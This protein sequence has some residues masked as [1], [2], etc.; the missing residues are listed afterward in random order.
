MAAP[1][2]RP[3]PITV[4]C[5]VGFLS[6]LIRMILIASPYSLRA[7]RAWVPPLLSLSALLLV[8]GSYFLF[9]MGRLGVWL[10]MGVLALQGIIVSLIPGGVGGLPVFAVPAL[11]L[12]VGGAYWK[13]LA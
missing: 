8:A 2:S 11:G 12:A 3:W 1:S 7:G 9:R 4:F 10:L 13:R 5:A 6:A